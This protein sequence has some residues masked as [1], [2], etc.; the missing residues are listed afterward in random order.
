ML[1]ASLADALWMTRELFDSP[2]SS[3]WRISKSME[4]LLR[5]F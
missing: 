3:G 2:I 1:H 5:K 4:N